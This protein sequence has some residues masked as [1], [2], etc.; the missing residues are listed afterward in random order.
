MTNQEVGRRIREARESKR[1][2]QKELAEKAGVAPSTILRYEQGKIKQIKLPIIQSIA[3]ILG[4][5]PSWLI[6]KS[7]DREVSTKSESYYINDETKKL[8]QDIRNNPNLGIL[9]DATRN[10]KSEDLKAV[11]AIAERLG[12]ND[13]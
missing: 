9:L 13:N 12:G 2:M 6:G 10:L 8:A 7:E 3:N 5:N 11:I 4:V 1:I